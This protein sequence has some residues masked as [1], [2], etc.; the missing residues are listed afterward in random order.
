[1]SQHD[2]K[3]P[4][5]LTYEEAE[6][7]RRDPQWGHPVRDL[8]LHAAHWLET[9]IALHPERQAEIDAL[10]ER[11]DEATGD[12]SAAGDHPEWRWR[13]A[14]DGEVVVALHEIVAVMRDAAPLLK[15]PEDS[16]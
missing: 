13:P 7:N 9:A 8:A 2:D 3:E 6:A 5:C 4:M 11:L 1:M 15:K 12:I 14:T 10:S 16:Q